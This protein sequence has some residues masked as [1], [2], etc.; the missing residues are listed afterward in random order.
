MIISPKALLSL[1]FLIVNQLKSTIYIENNEFLCIIIS[2]DKMNFKKQKMI[3]SECGFSCDLRTVKAFPL[4]GHDYYEMELTLKGE[5]TALVNKKQISLCRGTLCFM[6]PGDIH[7]I[8][9]NEEIVTFNLSFDERLWDP[10][11][12]IKLPY[13]RE[14]KEESV[15]LVEELYSL[16]AKSKDAFSGRT[17]A[18][19]IISLCTKD[20]SLENCDDAVAK[21]KE[22]ITRHFRENPGLKLCAEFVGLSPNSQRRVDLGTVPRSTRGLFLGEWDGAPP[23]GVG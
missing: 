17:L 7:A 4:H 18:N 14:L 13:I 16:L 15:F 21:A 5:S 20:A 11:I 2:G 23:Y 12:K 1:V 3:N 22:Y 9:G 8:T 10:P 19:A 6:A